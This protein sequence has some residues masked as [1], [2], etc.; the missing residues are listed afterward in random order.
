MQDV[1]CE[2]KI[3]QRMISF[4]ARLNPDFINIRKKLELLFQIEIV[5][6]ECQERFS[7]PNVLNALLKKV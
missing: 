7:G 1:L 3:R 2:S 5:Y 4:S 6:S